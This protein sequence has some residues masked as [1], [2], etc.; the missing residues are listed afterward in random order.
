MLEDAGVDYTNSAEELYG[1]T[2]M[3]HGLRTGAIAKVAAAIPKSQNSAR[4][5][6]QGEKREHGPVFFPP[7]IW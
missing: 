3:M 1:P 4:G 2:G 6:Q 5:S 7:A